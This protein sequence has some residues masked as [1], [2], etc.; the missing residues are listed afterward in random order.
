MSKPNLTVPSQEISQPN[1][2]GNFEQTEQI[3]NTL[4]APIYNE[5]LTKNYQ[6]EGRLGNPH[7]FMAYATWLREI[8]SIKDKRVL[9]LA[10]GSGDSSRMLADKGANV[11]GVDISETML[12]IAKSKNDGI[13]YILAD[14]S[15]PKKY[16]EQPFDKVVGAFLFNYASSIEKLD[17]MLRNV[18]DNLKSGE[19]FTTITISPEH[20][21]I[22]PWKHISHSTEW[23]GKPFV[24][25]AGIETTLRTQDGE[26]ICDFR[27]F[28]WTRETYENLFIKNGFKDVK[29][30]EL[31]MHNEGKILDNWQEIEKQNMLVVIKATKI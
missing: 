29:Y 26:K 10:C 31:K 20:P 11:V 16:S 21:I 5:N 28:Y 24:D 6:N 3:T 14:A 27:S 7:Q 9:D 8:G 13:L 2:V 18:A 4:Q 1:V 17:G 22:K 19:E 30:I 23:K 12:D 25:G 15:S